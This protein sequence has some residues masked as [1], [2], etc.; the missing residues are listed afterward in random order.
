MVRQK[1]IKRSDLLYLGGLFDGEGCAGVYRGQSWNERRKRYYP[2]QF[3]LL[4]VQMADTEPL[5]LLHSLFGGSYCRAT[6]KIRRRK[7]GSPYKVLYL[8]KVSCRQ[9]QAV[10]KILL[11]FVRTA[12]KQR[13][14]RRVLVHYT[15][16]PTGWWR[17]GKQQ[18]LGVKLLRARKLKYPGKPK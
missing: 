4:Q 5:R 14:I 16:F 6:Y 18:G 17:R 12:A 8:W 15:K 1:R 9:A 3:P 13:A 7:D 2:Y 10:A 11:P